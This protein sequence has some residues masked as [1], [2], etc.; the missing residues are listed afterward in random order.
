MSCSVDIIFIVSLLST[1][2]LTSA[3]IYPQDVRGI[4]GKLHAKVDEGTRI[5]MRHGKTLEE[6]YIG[7]AKI[8]TEKRGEESD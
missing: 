2:D 7:N 4:C 3:V 1:P 6:R 8:F 5:L